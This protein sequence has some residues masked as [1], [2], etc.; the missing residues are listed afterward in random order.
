MPITPG[1]KV[2]IKD[3]FPHQSDG[4]PFETT[5]SHDK[6]LHGRTGA[7]V[8]NDRK[9]NNVVNFDNPEGDDDWGYFYDHELEII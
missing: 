7:V 4:S 1:T 8:R 9:Y 5:S 3:T 2:K 6:S